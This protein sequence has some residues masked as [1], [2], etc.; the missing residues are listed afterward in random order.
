M[1]RASG[2][3]DAFSPYPGLQLPCVSLLN[4]YP[5]PPPALPL[6]LLWPVSHGYHRN[7]DAWSWSL[8]HPLALWLCLGEKLYVTDKGPHPRGARAGAWGPV[9]R[10]SPHMPHKATPELR[11]LQASLMLHGPWPED[12][13]TGG[14][15]GRLAW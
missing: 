15:Q 11:V 2:M 8:Q 7:W 5:A 6:M 13:L 12:T 14:S 1:S 9:G 10:G 3:R 4:P